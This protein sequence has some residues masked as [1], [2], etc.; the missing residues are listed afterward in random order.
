MV[1]PSYFRLFRL[2]LVSYAASAALTSLSAAPSI[3]YDSGDPTST[4]QYLLERINVARANPAAEGEMLAN[5]AAG[6]TNIAANYS[7]Y[8]VNVNVL[9]SQFA[10]Y[11]ARPPLAMNKILMGTARAHSQDQAV[12]GVQSHDGT[13]GSQFSSRIAQAGYTQ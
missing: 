7:H 6:D 8:G 3:P 5:A 11:A 13:D 4:E 9:R 1:L 2:A 12:S 10:S